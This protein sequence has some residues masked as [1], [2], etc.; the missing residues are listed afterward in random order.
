MSNEER[1]ASKTTSHEKSFMQRNVMKP[2]LTLT[3][4]ISLL[5]LTPLGMVSVYTAKVLIGI[6]VAVFLRTL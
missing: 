2:E 1:R 3:V 4:I 5:V 6:V